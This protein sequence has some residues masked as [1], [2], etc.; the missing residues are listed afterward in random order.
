MCTFIQC[1]EAKKRE[2]LSFFNQVLTHLKEVGPQKTK[3]EHWQLSWSRNSSSN[4]PVPAVPLCTALTL[5]QSGLIRVSAHFTSYHAV[6]EWELF[7]V[8]QWK[9]DKNYNDNDKWKL[10]EIGC[11]YVNSCLAVFEI[12]TLDLPRQ[13]IHISTVWKCVR[14]NTQHTSCLYRYQFMCGAM[15]CK[16][17]EVRTTLRPVIYRGPSERIRTS[18]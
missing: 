1:W 6:C 18:Y 9:E 7:Q 2:Y 17:G 14:D 8:Y 10:C 11:F 12:S 5:Q 16:E 13:N 4:N 15:C 3:A